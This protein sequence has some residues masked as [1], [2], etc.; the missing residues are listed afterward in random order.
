MNNILPT[1]EQRA[2]W[3]LKAAAT[4]RANADA[5]NEA[6]R[7]KRLLV[8]EI[9]ELEKRRDSLM[10]HCANSTLAAELTGSGLC[11]E[12]VLVKK[13]VAWKAVCGVYFLIKDQKV[14]Y[15]GQSVDIFRRISNHA[16]KIDFDRIAYEPCKEQYLDWLESV[17]IHFLQ[18][19]LNG[20]RR[21]GIINAPIPLHLIVPYRPGSTESAEARS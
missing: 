8:D 9:E 5:R 10:A 14:I 6:Q 7:R 19:P 20:R 4:R 16:T 15:V 12:S 2:E 13:S 17:Y 1:A 18:P 21:S 3:A 11:A